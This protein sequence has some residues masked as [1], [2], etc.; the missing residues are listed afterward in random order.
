MVTDAILNLFYGSLSGFISL[1]PDATPITF[2]QLANS[3]NLTVMIAR[4]SAFVPVEPVL[5]GLL[6]CCVAF[7]VS[8]LR[9]ISKHVR[10]F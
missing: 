8:I 7:V 3:P 9:A 6:W 1:L 2:G 5:N 4:I 10:L